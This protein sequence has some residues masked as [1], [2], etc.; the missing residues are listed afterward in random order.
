MSP[1][2]KARAV[3]LGLLRVDPFA[4]AAALAD[5]A[6]SEPNDGPGPDGDRCPLSRPARRPE[7]QP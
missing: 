3:E 6:P 2:E 7:D 1:E 4:F 5:A